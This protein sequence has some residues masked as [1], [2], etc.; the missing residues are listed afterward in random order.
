MNKYFEKFGAI[1]KEELKDSQKARKVLD[2]LRGS[3]EIEAYQAQANTIAVKR[4][5]YNDH[6]RTHSEIVAA[7]GLKILRILTKKGEKPSVVKDHGWGYEDAQI[8][9]LVAAY[10]HD[11]GNSIHRDEHE[12]LSIAIARPILYDLL[13]T[14]FGGTKLHLMIAEIL[15]AIYSH[16]DDVE[17]LTLEAGVVTLADATDSAQ[18]RSRI[19][20]KL[21]DI[22]MHVISS[23]AIDEVNILQGDRKPLKLE[24]LMNNAAGIFQIERVFIPKI[25]TSGLKDRVEVVAKIGGGKQIV[26]EFRV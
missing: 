6:G 17:C 12:A 20:F 25:K 26:K 3:E 15:H 8:V 4:M 9:V 21:G 16:A 24:L 10:L 13:S 5:G 22:D 23:Q 7:N 18:G 14:Q 1:Y 2:L 11:I 19:P